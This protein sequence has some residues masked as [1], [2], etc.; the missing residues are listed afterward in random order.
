MPQ[1][2]ARRGPSRSE[3]NIAD[4]AGTMRYEKTRRTPAIGT[5]DV[6]TNPKVA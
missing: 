4:T 3:K 1:P 2:I 6:T 5:D